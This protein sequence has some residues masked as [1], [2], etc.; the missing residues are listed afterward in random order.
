[1][2]FGDNTKAALMTRGLMEMTQLGVAHGAKALTF[3]GLSGVGDLMATASSRLSRNYR[4]GMGLAAG[5]PLDEVLTDVRQAAEG[6]PTA[7]AAHVLMQRYGL[8]L[9]V[10]ST[11]YSVIH[12]GLSPLEG[13]EGLMCRDAR[14]EFGE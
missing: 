11:L 13:V 10:F 12:E 5:K 3:L 1:M 14:S 4:V 8:E 9:P 7:R 2:G 6:V